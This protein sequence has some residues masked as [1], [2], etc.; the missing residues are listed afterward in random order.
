ME[1]KPL[2][3]S[4]IKIPPEDW[5]RTPPSVQ[6]ALLQVLDRVAVLE[7]ELNKL[8][9]EV[10]RL[11]EQTR[12]SSRNSAPPPSS[13]PPDKPPRR[14]RK[15]SGKKRGAQPGHEGQPRIPKDRGARC[16]IASARRRRACPV[17]QI[18]RVVASRPRWHVDPRTLCGSRRRA[19]RC[20]PKMACRGRCL[21]SSA[22]G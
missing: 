8:R 11:R 12:A 5:A 13:A 16:R 22:W 6:Q 15:A 7:E 19:S 10:E 4:K 1:S 17:P 21:Q 14:E 20:R 2:T 18:V 9:S 3:S